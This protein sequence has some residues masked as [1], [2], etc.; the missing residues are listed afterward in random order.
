[1]QHVQAGLVPEHFDFLC[2]HCVQALITCGG[3]F[4]IL[5]AFWLVS[6]P[7]TDLDSRL[8]RFDLDSE[9]F[10]GQSR[11]S[12]LQPSQGRQPEH[13][14]FLPLHRRQAVFAGWDL[15]LLPPS[16]EASLLIATLL[17]CWRLT[18]LMLTEIY[19]VSDF[20]VVCN[21]VLGT[22]GAT[23]GLS[24][25]D[26]LL[27]SNVSESVCSIQSAKVRLKE[28]C[29]SSMFQDVLWNPKKWMGLVHS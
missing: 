4:F 19:W 6:A 17:D 20:C 18:P 21:N 26:N 23:E 16:W 25:L 28:L 3:A 2:W 7:S 12:L 24:L 15:T 1:M 27:L 13:L 5:V 29:A 8:C 22:S 10:Q 9:P 11:P 14:D